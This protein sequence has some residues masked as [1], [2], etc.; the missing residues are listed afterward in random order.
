[1][2]KILA[3][4]LA[5]LSISAFAQT[6]PLVVDVPGVKTADIINAANSTF[7]NPQRHISADT[8][9][10]R[11]NY[12][13]DNGNGLFGM[14]AYSNY[15]ADIVVEAKDEKF[16]V[17]LKNVRDRDSLQS[18]DS[19]NDTSFGQKAKQFCIQGAKDYQASLV[20]QIKN[21]IGSRSAW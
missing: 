21:A 7:R 19:F 6:E 4:A 17:I 16:R 10:T 12:R 14:T 20:T 11:G 5:A 15:E 3:I 8:I 18:C 9:V 2:K 13:A 1:M